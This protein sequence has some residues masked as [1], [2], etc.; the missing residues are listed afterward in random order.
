MM[1]LPAV[2]LGIFHARMPG[3]AG[4]ND[5]ETLQCCAVEQQVLPYVR[6]PA[7]LSCELTRGDVEC[8]LIAFSDAEGNF[9][10]SFYDVKFILSTCQ[11]CGHAVALSL[12]SCT[13]K[14]TSCPFE[15]TLF[16]FIRH[17]QGQS[18]LAFSCFAALTE[19]HEHSPTT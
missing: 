10:D 14:D 17:L 8:S 7:E 16:H 6:I 11:W 1:T 5:L 13:E 4:L 15:S 3:H 2:T 12:A 18:V 9:G 19:A